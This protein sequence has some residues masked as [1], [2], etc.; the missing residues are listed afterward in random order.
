MKPRVI[1]SLTISVVVLILITLC[2]TKISNVEQQ[3]SELRVELQDSCNMSVSTICAPTLPGEANATNVTR[4]NNEDDRLHVNNQLE[5]FN[6]L[7]NI[8]HLRVCASQWLD[9][10]LTVR[11]MLHCIDDYAKKASGPLETR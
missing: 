4:A 1:L 7:E 8:T 9:S 6:Y 5:L 3:L 10:V 2:M 11:E